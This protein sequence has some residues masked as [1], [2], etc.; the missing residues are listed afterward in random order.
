MSAQTD[1]YDVDTDDEEL[2]SAVSDEPDDELDRIDPIPE[3]LTL[4]GG[5]EVHLLPLRTRQLFKLLRIITHG[6]GQQ[7]LTSGID[8]NDDA[9]VF[10]Q[11]LLGLVLFSIPDAEQEAIDFLQAMVEP[12]DLCEKQVRDMTKAER[13][14]NIASWTTLNMELYNPD[15]SDTIDIIEVI[16]QRESGDLQALGKRLRQFLELA[17]KTGQLK[18]E[19]SSNGA[20]SRPQQEV[21]LPESSPESST[22]SP[23][24]TGG[25][26]KRSSTSPSDESAKSSR[27]SRRASGG[28]S[29]SAGS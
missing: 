26:T 7:L 25:R 23:R 18:A 12:G 9:Q 5:I 14:G 8:F 22:S 15:P 17:A 1:E 29:A 16:V 10:I 3:Y 27:P 24:S 28:K 6:A 4:K 21:N 2:T 13:E 19:P 20:G 11:K